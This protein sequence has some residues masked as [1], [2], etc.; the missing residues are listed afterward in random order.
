MLRRALLRSRSSIALN[1]SRALAPSF[2]A[3]ALS[4]DDDAKAKTRAQAEAEAAKKINAGAS[5]LF[6]WTEV[7]VSNADRPIPRWQNAAFVVVVGAFFAYFGNKLVTSELSRRE[8][9]RDAREALETR[10]RDVVRATMGD[11]NEFDLDAVVDEDALEGLTPEEI[12]ALVER[13]R[14]ARGGERDAS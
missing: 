14:D 10:A 8:R 6:S 1:A 12:A 7:D 11:R 13:E 5:P 4:T 9:A 2:K 3:R